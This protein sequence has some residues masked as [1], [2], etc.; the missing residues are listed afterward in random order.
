MKQ[1]GKDTGDN[2]F[3]FQV[4]IL[5]HAETNGQALEQ[6]LHVLNSGDFSDFRV[7]TGVQLGRVIDEA[8]AQDKKKTAAA[9]AASVKATVE[10]AQ[11]A[12][13]V[14]KAKDAVAKAKDQ[15]APPAKPQAASSNTPDDLVQRIQQYIKTNR[16]IRINVNKGRGVK[17]SMPCRMISYDPSTEVLTVYHVDEKQV[18][19]FR[20]SEI[21]DFVE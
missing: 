3:L 19:S 1:T 11:V 4:D 18:H 10:K 16:L 6:L 15:P 21:D 9:A 8:L 20:F 17:L 12:A 2:S 5:V 7:S 14:A 13:A